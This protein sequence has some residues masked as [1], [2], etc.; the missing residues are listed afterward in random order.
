MK[1]GIGFSCTE[2]RRQR[3][4]EQEKP[5]EASLSEQ[6][7]SEWI[8]QEP[9]YPE[10]EL[11]NRKTGTPRNLEEVLATPCKYDK[12]LKNKVNND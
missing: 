9:N 12:I 11:Q 2:L 8:N 7:W 6:S 4:E 5:P 3:R 10:L 1:P